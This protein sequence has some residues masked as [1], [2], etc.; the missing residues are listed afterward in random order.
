MEG[1]IELSHKDICE[2]LAKVVSTLPE[3][4]TISEID[5]SRV[6][7]SIRSKISH[8]KM[9]EQGLIH[10]TARIEMAVYS[11]INTLDEFVSDFA[12]KNL[13]VSASV[14]DGKLRN[15]IYKD[16]LHIS[17]GQPVIYR[18]KYYYD[19]I[20][21]TCYVS[22]S[23]TNSSRSFD[24]FSAIIKKL[25]ILKESGKNVTIKIDEYIHMYETI[26]NY[27]VSINKEAI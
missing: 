19:Y 24:S 17:L 22:N 6:V 26:N 8:S 9:F 25:E 1:T 15:V 14:I 27:L 10:Y 20:P 4:D 2:I 16:H 12:R 11:D 18:G 5:L 7:S 21:L 13:N 23:L 3:D